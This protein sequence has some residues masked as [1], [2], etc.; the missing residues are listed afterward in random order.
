MRRG[1]H[2]P[3]NSFSPESG[4]A[5]P[6]ALRRSSIAVRKSMLVASEAKTRRKHRSL[7]VL[8]GRWSDFC[9]TSRGFNSPRESPHSVYGLLADI[10]RTRTTEDQD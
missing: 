10:G 1:F 4:S 5:F 7:Q 9:G 2:G 6:K 8:N 3:R